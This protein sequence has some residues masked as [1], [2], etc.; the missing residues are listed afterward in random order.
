MSGSIDAGPPV[1]PMRHDDLDRVIEIDRAVGWP[2]ARDRF[3]YLL[4]DEDTHALVA[5]V[6]DVVAGFAFA[7]VR[8]PVG[9]LGAVAT[10]PVYRRRGIGG[11]LCAAA[12]AW[13]RAD[14]RCDAAILEALP[15]NVSAIGIYTRLGFV[16]TG[17]APLCGLPR[18]ELPSPPP[19]AASSA[20]HEVTPLGAGDWQTLLALDDAYWGGWREQDLL[21]WLSEGPELARLL[22][23]DGQPRGYCLVERANGRIGPLAAPSLAGF[24]ALLD[25]VLRSDALRVGTSPYVSLRPVD[26]DAATL[27][28]LA[29]RSLHPVPELR[30]VRMEKV[31]RRPLRRQHGFYV[32]ARPEKG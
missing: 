12:D 2:H 13:L 17:E 7:G 29:A 8:E 10:D 32:S 19:P 27:A 15:G 1:R 30:H 26:P 20:T 4:E 18:G 11:A 9:W 25:D 24:L 6:G 21:Y 23:I 5:E 31:Y 16:A 3:Q 22:R 28:A 14:P